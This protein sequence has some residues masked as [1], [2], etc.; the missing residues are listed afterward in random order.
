M[1]SPDSHVHEKKA[2]DKHRDLFQGGP[3]VAA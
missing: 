1:V 3:K 2:V